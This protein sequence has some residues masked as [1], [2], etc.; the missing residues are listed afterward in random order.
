MAEILVEETI[1]ENAV[2]VSPKARLEKFLR[3]NKVKV[4]TEKDFDFPKD[5]KTQAKI[6]AE[7]D[8]FLQMRE[9]WREIDRKLEKERNKWQ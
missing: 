8:E 6:R 7:V 2:E 3:E 9:E 1:K 4:F 5:E